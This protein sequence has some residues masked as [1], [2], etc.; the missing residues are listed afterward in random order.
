MKGL[1]FSTI[2]LRNKLPKSHTKTNYLIITQVATVNNTTL[3]V[4]VDIYQSAQSCWQ[5]IGDEPKNEIVFIM[6]H[7]ERISSHHGQSALQPPPKSHD[8]S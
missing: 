1:H 3:Q 2:D 8:E 5:E 6:Q 7:L 4:R